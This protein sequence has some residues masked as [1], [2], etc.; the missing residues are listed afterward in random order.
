MAED[1][2]VKHTKKVYSIWFSKE[3]NIL[4][5]IS[6]FLVE[7]LIIVFAVSISIWFHNRSEHAHQQAEVKRFL[8]GLKSDLNQD[9]GEISNDMQS[10]MNQ[11]KIFT[12]ISNLRMNEIPNR[13]TIIKYRNFLFNTT[14]LDPNDGR[15]QGFKSS[16]KIGNIENDSLQNDIMD[17]Y[18]EDIPALLGSSRM[19]ISIKLKLLDFYFKNQKR[20]TDSTTNYLD[21]FKYDEVRNLSGSLSGTSEVMERYN[22]CIQLMNKLIG[23][24]DRQYD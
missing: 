5:K 1:E 4:H 6:E 11:G 17:L 13:D 23:E 18:E 16:G 21:L 14:E 7:I 22:K 19:Y 3:H 12:Y 24:I 20:L 15:F 2:I 10:Y 8:Q 9:I